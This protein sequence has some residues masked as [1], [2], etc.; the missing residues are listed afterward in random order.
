[1]KVLNFNNKVKEYM[2]LIKNIEY[3]FEIFRSIELNTK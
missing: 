3:D 2:D 1:M